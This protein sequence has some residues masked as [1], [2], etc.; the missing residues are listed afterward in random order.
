MMK[1]ARN[2]YSKKT[3]NN[4]NHTNQTPFGNFPIPDLEHLTITTPRLY[5]IALR[6]LAPLHHCAFYIASL[7]H[8]TP[9]IVPLFPVAPRHRTPAPYQFCYVFSFFA[10]FFFWKL[11]RCRGAVQGCGAG[12]NGTMGAAS[13]CMGAIYTVH[14]C[15]QLVQRCN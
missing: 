9:Y 8:C 7:H 15:N 1:N 14:G 2:M 12:C 10:M 6:T 13:W 4:E 11:V 5:I 3:S